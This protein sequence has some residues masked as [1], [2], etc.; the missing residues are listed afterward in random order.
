MVKYIIGQGIDKSRVT[1]NGYGETNFIAINEKGSGE[2]APEGR[3]F[4]RRVEFHVLSGGDEVL[5]KEKVEVPSSIK[6]K[7]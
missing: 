4:N 2:D 7:E 6:I 5:I 1:A 3:K